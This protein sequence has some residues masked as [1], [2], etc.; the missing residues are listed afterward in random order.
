MPKL[1]RTTHCGVQGHG[2]HCELSH[3]RTDSL[4]LKGRLNRLARRQ[5]KMDEKEA[6]FYEQG[7]DIT[8]CDI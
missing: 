5:A 7:K 2:T 4:M 1:P 6:E 8:G 3:E